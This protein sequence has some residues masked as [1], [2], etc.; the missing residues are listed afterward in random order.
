MIIDDQRWR[1]LLADRAERP[2]LVRAKA[3]ARR[4]RPLL[5]RDG[6]L[7]LVAADH[8]A[9]N[10]YRVGNDPLAMADRRRLLE[11][12]VVALRRPGVDGLLATP[13][14]VEELLLLDELHDQVVIGSMNR[15]GLTGSVWSLDDR[16]TAYDAATIERMGLEG[17]KMLLRVD[18]SDPGTNLT[19]EAC[20]HSVSDL[21]SRKLMA[22]VEGLPAHRDADGHVR[23]SEDPDELIH[24][25]GV[26]AALGVTS[27]YTWLKLPAADERVMATTTLPTLL[28]GGDPGDREAELFAKWQRAMAIPQVR[29]LVAG[30]SLLYPKSGDVAAVVDLAV[31]VVHG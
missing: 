29:G 23:V 15:G 8:V 12:V 26:C 25:V 21:A 16:F 28:L 20:A 9:R 11:N 27:A 2:E 18:L 22:M 7:M 19:I 31:K 13:D 17:G 24:V 5:G 6:R 10:I 14:V 4:R 3:D 30:R 1:K